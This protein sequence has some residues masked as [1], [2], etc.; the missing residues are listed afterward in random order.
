MQVLRR[1][2]KEEALVEEL[3]LR[4]PDKRPVIYSLLIFILLFK[5]S[6][7]KIRRL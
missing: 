4:L 7:V 1:V 5:F 3:L 6:S 2:F